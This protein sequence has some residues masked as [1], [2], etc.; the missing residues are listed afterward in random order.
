MN[1][2][3]YIA[4]LEE[5]LSKLSDMYKGRI[6]NIEMILNRNSL[7]LEE[8]KLILESVDFCYRLGQGVGRI[9]KEHENYKDEMKKR[10]E[11][12]KVIK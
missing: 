5:N 7:D 6:S 10:R 8:T 4:G 2:K 11:S 3:E 1:T 9:E 12:I